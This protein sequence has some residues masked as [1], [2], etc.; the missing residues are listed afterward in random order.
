MLSRGRSRTYPDL[1]WQ[2]LNAGKTA[3]DS[4]R[5]RGL[6]PEAVVLELAREL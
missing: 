6:L 1:L 5:A 4:G 3:V 2:H